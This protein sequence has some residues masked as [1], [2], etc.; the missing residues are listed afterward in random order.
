MAGP[1]HNA[2]NHAPSGGTMPVANTAN[3][4]QSAPDWRYWPLWIS[5]LVHVLF[6]GFLSCTREWGGGCAAA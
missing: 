1:D 5:L 6:F 2:P 3:R 4:K